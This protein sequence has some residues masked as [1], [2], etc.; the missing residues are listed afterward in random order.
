MSGISLQSQ[1]QNSYH[2]PLILQWNSRYDQEDPDEAGG[3]SNLTSGALTLPVQI[4]YP[5]G[6]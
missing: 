4:L 1:F 5:T 2:S 6:A 3:S